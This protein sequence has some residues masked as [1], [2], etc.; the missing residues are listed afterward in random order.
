MSSLL[1]ITT[2]KDVIAYSYLRKA[3]Y[4]YA[5]SGIECAT[6]ELNKIYS[7]QEDEGHFLGAIISLLKN[8]I[9]QNITDQW[10]EKHT[11][12]ALHI[13]Q[14]HERLLSLG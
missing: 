1:S 4:G 5:I 8:P 10:K 9:P 13:M 6:A 12:R 11:K 3:H 7:F 2:K 14:R